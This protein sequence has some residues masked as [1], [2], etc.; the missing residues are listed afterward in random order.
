[1]GVGA[2]GDKLAAAG[3]PV[4][5]NG[6]PFRDGLA[7]VGVQLNPPPALRSG[8]EN[9]VD[10]LPIALQAHRGGHI[11]QG[12]DDVSQYVVKI[13]DRQLCHGG[14][15]VVQ[16]VITGAGFAVVPIEEVRPSG[17]GAQIVDGANDKVQLRH[18]QNFSGGFRVNVSHAKLQPQLELEAV[19][20]HRDRGP[21]LGQS[22]VPVELVHIQP[23]FVQQ[24]AVVGDAQLCQPLPH[25]GQGHIV[26]GGGAVKGNLAV[27]VEIGEIHDLETPPKKTPRTK[28]TP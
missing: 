8:A 26:Q 27:C 13:R 1:M 11:P 15:V 24:I 22:A 6:P 3:F 25:S 7:L 17:L 19:G 28:P 20:V 12:V 10:L 18:I 21:V 14:K 5:Q 4:L 2:Q 9:G 16:G 23:V